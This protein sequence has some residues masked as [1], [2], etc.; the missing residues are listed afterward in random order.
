MDDLERLLREKL[1]EAEKSLA[2]VQARFEQAERVYHR[3]S[4]V[5]TQAISDRDR[6]Q[7]FVFNLYDEKPDADEEPTPTERQ[8]NEALREMER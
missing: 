4:R 8:M 3:L 6:V 7:D 5:L 1:A 2:D